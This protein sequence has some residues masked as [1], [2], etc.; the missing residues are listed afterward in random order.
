MRNAAGYYRRHR[1]GRQSY[2]EKSRPAHN[3]GE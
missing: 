2:A 3:S 1:R